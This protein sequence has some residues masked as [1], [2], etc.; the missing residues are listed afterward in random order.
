MIAVSS[1]WA[2]IEARER[3]IF[4]QIR[5]GEFKYDPTN[6]AFAPNRPEQ[7]IPKQRFEEAVE[8]LPLPDMVPVQHLRGLSNIYSVLMGRRIR[9][10][11][12]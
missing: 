12:W 7:P 6:T 5:G 4:T 8:L 3:Q 10:S 1:I 9:Q 2:H 11:D